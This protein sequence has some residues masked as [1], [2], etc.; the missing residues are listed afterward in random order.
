MTTQRPLDIATK[1]YFYLIE[2]ISE[3]ISKQISEPI[4]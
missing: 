3:K 1:N 2:Q 4:F